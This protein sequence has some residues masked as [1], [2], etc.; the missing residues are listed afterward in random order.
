MDNHNNDP[1]DE[2]L[3]GGAG[4]TGANNIDNNV[5]PVDGQDEARV[6]LDPQARRLFERMADDFDQQIRD[7]QHAADTRLQHELAQQNNHH[8]AQMADLRRQMQ[9]LVNQQAAAA[10][11]QQAVAAAAAQQQAAA[12][13]QAAAA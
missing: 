8:Q 10:A 1:D 13:A 4:V 12:A 5:D 6:R 2:A 11:Q 9:D 7:Q 3:G